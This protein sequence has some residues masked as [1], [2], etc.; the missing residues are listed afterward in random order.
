MKLLKN[1]F[2]LNCLFPEIKVQCLLIKEYF[3]RQ[4]DLFGGHIVFLISG[5]GVMQYLF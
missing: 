3:K 5:E 1:H 2:S 4:K